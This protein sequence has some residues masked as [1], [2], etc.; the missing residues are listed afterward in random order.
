MEFTSNTGGGANS[1]ARL[2]AVENAIAAEEAAREAADTKIKGMI[3]DTDVGVLSARMNDAEAVLEQLGTPT[4]KTM[5]TN[6]TTS[7]YLNSDGSV[8]AST[9]RKCSDY[10]DISGA[11]TVDIINAI[12]ISA[13]NYTY[14]AFYDSDKD[15]IQAL[16]YTKASESVTVSGIEVPEGAKYMR[17]TV[18]PTGASKC[19]LH[20]PNEI[21]EYIGN[22]IYPLSNKTIAFFGGSVCKYMN[23][24]GVSSEL[25]YKMT[26]AAYGFY[27]VYGDGYANLTTIS[28]GVATMGG[29]P[30]QVD[31]FISSGKSADIFVLWSSTNDLWSVLP[32]DSTD[33]ISADSFDITKLATQSG[34]MNYCINKLQTNFPSSKILIIGSLKH[35]Q[36]ENGYGVNG[37]LHNLVKAQ[38]EV[39]QRNSLPFYSLWENSGINEYNYTNYISLTTSTGAVDKIHPTADGYRYFVPKMLRWIVDNAV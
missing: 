31:D 4:S 32:G 13:A 35:F 2:T 27:S 9:G 24:Y 37:N 19:T 15:L 20:I 28:D 6:P 22:V 29:M 18:D 12:A 3:A 1:D 36:D 10:I 21:N 39:A 17:A 34:G 25:I 7:G 38:Q 23:D 11:A 5:S 14:A 8:A 16:K 33:Y 26:G 30:K